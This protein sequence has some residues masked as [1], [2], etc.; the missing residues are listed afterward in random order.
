MCAK[1]RKCEFDNTKQGREAIPTCTKFIN[2]FGFF[3]GER[4]PI[5]LSFGKTNYNEGKKMYSLAKVTMQNIWNHA[6]ELNDKTMAKNG[7]EWSI[8]AINAAGAT[9]DEDREFAMGLFK[10]FR[11]TIL[12][13]D[14]SEG[15]ADEETTGPSSSIE[16]TEF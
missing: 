14:L 4:M 9:S 15:T 16:G 12:N 1:C 3:E 11:G 13:Y 6:Y 10:Q 5:I 7:N 8:I 2:F